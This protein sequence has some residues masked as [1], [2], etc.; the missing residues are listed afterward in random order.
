MRLV[1]NVKAEFDTGRRFAMFTLFKKLA[2][3][4]KY[5]FKQI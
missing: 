2:C 4:N 3:D 1:F 5:I